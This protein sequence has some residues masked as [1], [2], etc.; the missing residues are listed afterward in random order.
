MPSPLRL[1]EKLLRSVIDVFADCGGSRNECIVYVT[2]PLERRDDANGF[3]HPVH[4][5]SPV[6]TTVDSE[7]LHLVWDGLRQTGSRIVLQVHSHPGTAFHS[8]IDDRFPIVHSVGFLSLVLPSFGRLGLQG[9]HVAVHTGN[10]KW[11]SPAQDQWSRYI[12]IQ[13][14]S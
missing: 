13:D 1:S 14:A 5:S 6:S 4:A 12:V 9:A 11:L 2:A 10:G 3:V 8:S 7:E